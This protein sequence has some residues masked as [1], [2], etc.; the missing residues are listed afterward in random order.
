MTQPVYDSREIGAPYRLTTSTS[1]GYRREQQLDDP[2]HVTSVWVGRRTLLRALLRGGLEVGVSV[3]APHDLAE[4]VLELDDNYRGE[5]GSERRRECDARLNDAL[6]EFARP[7]SYGMERVE[8]P[9]F[10]APPLKPNDHGIVRR[11]P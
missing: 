11:L 4:A 9:P 2:F 8:V 7:V 5:T 6:D 3:H 10:D 1:E